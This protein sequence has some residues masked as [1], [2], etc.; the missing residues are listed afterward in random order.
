MLDCLHRLGFLSLHGTSAE[1]PRPPHGDA[2]PGARLPRREAGLE[3]RPR[4]SPTAHP[5]R[6]GGR[7]SSPNMLPWSASPVDLPL[8][9]VARS[10]GAAVVILPPRRRSGP[11]GR[12]PP[13][14]PLRLL[15]PEESLR[16]EFTP[17][18]APAGTAFLLGAFDLSADAE[19]EGEPLLK[20]ANDLQGPP[21]R[22]L[23]PATDRCPR[24]AGD[25]GPR[26]DRRT[27]HRGG[28]PSQGLPAPATRDSASATGWTP[29]G[30]TPTAFLRGWIHA[31]VRALRIESA[32][33]DRAG[34]CLHRPPR[35]PTIRSTSTSAMP[36]SPSISPARPSGEPGAGDRRRHR[37][38][39][40]PRFRRGRSR[41]SEVSGRM[42]A[43]PASRRRCTFS[44][45]SAKHPRRPRR[46]PRAPGRRRR[47]S[48]GRR[49]ARCCVDR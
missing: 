29:S 37:L 11:R 15:R 5:G 25:C 36:A 3:D 6:R 4:C 23:R 30:A 24:G 9:V 44:S 47:A 34:G 45:T 21:R 12:R 42:T 18:E 32:G 1:S 22:R 38:P 41:W 28:P 10:R 49:R 26:P 31:R 17:F 35:S 7:S 13:P 33:H 20:A 8:D 2:Q 48:K 16:L 46:R 40:P 19:N 39:S 43:A 14:D 27:R